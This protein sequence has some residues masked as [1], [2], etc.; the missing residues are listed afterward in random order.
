MKKLYFL[1]LLLLATTTSFGQ[2][3]TEEFSY[4]DAALLTA[5]GWTAH[6]GGGTQAVDVGA[7]NGLTYTGYSTVGTNAA[8]LDNNGED[9]NKTFTPAVTSGSIYYS[10]LINVT[11]GDAGYFTHIGNLGT[12]VARIFIKPSTTAGKI[13]F[14][15]SNTSTASFATTPTDYDLNTTYL[16][17]VKYDV[18]TTG[19]CSLW[20]KSSGVPATEA[21]AGTP[22]HTNSGSGFATI[23][24]VYLRQYIATQ[25]ITIDAIK[26][27]QTWFGA[28]PCPLTLGT[29]VSTCNAVT[30]AIDTY[31]ISIP[32]TGGGSGTYTLSSNAGVVGGSNPTTTAT[33][34]ITITGVPEGT[35]VT[36]TVSGSCAFAKV[37]T[38]TSCKPINTLPFYDGFNYTA[39]T[40]L[41]NSQMWATVNSGDD[42][43]AQS[44]S[45]VYA[46]TPSV[47]TTGNSVTFSGAGA[48]AFTPFTPTTAGTVYTSFLI[49]VSDVSNVTDGSATYF[50]TLTDAN[51]A[52]YKAKIFVKRVATQY[53]IGLDTA[54]TTTSYDATLRNTGDVIRIVMA[55]DF[56]ANALNLWINPAASGSAP[57]LGLNP[58]GTGAI[59]TLGG[60]LLRQDSATLTPTIVF[61]ELRISTNLSDL[62]L[63]ALATDNFNEIA[64]LKVYAANGTLFVVSETNLDKTVA[65]YDLLGKQVVNAAVVNQTVNVTQLSAGI[66]VVKVT[67]DGK[68][69]TR[70]LVIR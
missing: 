53:Q 36:L 61:D 37:M 42:V 24:A 60:F 6:S 56:T 21:A 16:I 67:E 65:V 17:I 14:G 55:H 1:L 30:T 2:I 26:V 19:A 43:V 70:K 3:F 35:A 18:S 62:G 25:N 33:G 28:A 10:F 47:A 15:I 11:S 7:S 51:S 52:N 13:N 48:E 45:L 34:N 66:Y 54:T 44:I 50:A 9:V 57:N 40:A 41:G 49:N 32:Y 63:T 64:G 69:A 58:S 23:N 4:P 39:G 5:N 38:A 22:E 29:E 59:T 68:T 31:N 8:R 12:Y 20:V 27:Y 46:G